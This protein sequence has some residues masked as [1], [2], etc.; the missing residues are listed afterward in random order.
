MQLVFSSCE[1]RT[2]SWWFLQAA[3][4]FHLSLAISFIVDWVASV[5]Y[6]VE[7]LDNFYEMKFGYYVCFFATTLYETH[8]RCFKNRFIKTSYV[9]IIQICICLLDLILSLANLDKEKPRIFHTNMNQK[10]NN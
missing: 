10:G 1:T 3:N 2:C 5:T 9:Q 7:V 8:N 4:L 6:D